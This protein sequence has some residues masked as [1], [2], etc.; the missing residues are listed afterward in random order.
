MNTSML[1]NPGFSFFGIWEVKWYGVI[2][3][4]GMVLG[5]ILATFT[6]KAKGYEKSLVL[7][8]T[9]AAIP[10]AL[11]GARLY[12]CIFEGVDSFGE[13]FEVWNGGMAIYGGVI[14]GFLGLV[15]VSL[16]K[17]VP[18]LDLCDI[19]VPCLILGQAIG[20]WGNF[21]NQEAY[22]ALITNP[23]MQ[24]FPI[25]VYIDDMNFT[26]EAQQQVIKAY[27]S[28]A[29]VEG[30]WFNAT[31]FYES[32]W[33]LIGVVILMIICYKLKFSGIVTAVYFIYYG[34]GRAIIE[35]F[36]TDSLYL[37]GTKIKVSQ[38]LSIVLILVGLAIMTVIILKQKGIIPSKKPL[39]QT[40]S[41]DDSTQDKQESE[42]DETVEVEIVQDSTP[43]EPRLSDK[44]DTFNIDANE[45]LLKTIQMQNRDSNIEESEEQQPKPKQPSKAS[46]T[47]KS[48]SKPKSTKSTK[49]STKKPASTKTTTQK[50]KSKK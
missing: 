8:M 41:E 43:E 42:Q 21:V 47:K 13:I 37:W 3:A 14:G 40:V 2:I 4:V 28:L 30:A 46:S 39:A 36:R 1:L 5:L 15:I 33:N 22:G 48:S 27:G 12:Y 24:W 25:G 31:F 35:G 20:R 29:E 50:S 10:L 7:D 23:K 49:S 18:L 32:F 44:A 26:Y 17:K 34:I 11:V 16:V 6:S 45:Y 38:A 9:L 19:A